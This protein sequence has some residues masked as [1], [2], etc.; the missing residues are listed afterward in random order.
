V[1]V[2]LTSSCTFEISVKLE[3]LSD[4][5]SGHL[6]YSERSELIKIGWHL[7]NLSVEMILDLFDEGCI[8]RK[9]EVDGSTFST[10]TTSSTNSVDVVFLLEW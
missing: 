5:D 6:F 10:E 3:T 2:T 1:V 8:L 9:N 4:S 7:V